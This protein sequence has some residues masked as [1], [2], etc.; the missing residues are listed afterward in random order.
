[1]LGLG[2][3]LLGTL[4][5]LT[6]MPGVSFDNQLVAVVAA[7]VPVGLGARFAWVNRAWSAKAKITGFAA[8]MIGALIGASL[9][10]NATSSLLSI[11]TAIFGAAVGANLILLI[12]NMTG[13]TGDCPI[14][15]ASRRSECWRRQWPLPD[16]PGLRPLTSRR[17][18]PGNDQIRRFDRAAV[19]LLRGRVRGPFAWC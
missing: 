5:V 15:S 18:A 2:G 4:I 12:L 8:A 14:A 6:T 1:M 17:R 7:G 16:M 13:M 19:R 10:F 9:W 3:W 11:V